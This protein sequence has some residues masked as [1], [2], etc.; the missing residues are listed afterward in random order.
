MHILIT[1]DDGIEAAGLE[2]LL[3]AGA[4]FPAVGMELG[5]PV[6]EAELAWE[7]DGHKLCLLLDEEA[8][9]AS[10][11]EADGWSVVVATTDEPDWAARALRTLSD[12]LGIAPE[13]EE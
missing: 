11:L 5:E 9:A 3:A 13:E 4:P 1:N 8:A 10:A 2:A 7:V 6:A 12:V